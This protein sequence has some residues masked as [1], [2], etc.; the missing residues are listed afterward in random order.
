MRVGPP[1][2]LTTD[3]TPPATSILS[4]RLPAGL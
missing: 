3:K 4:A 1:G 2:G